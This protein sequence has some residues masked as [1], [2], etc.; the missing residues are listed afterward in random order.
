M[1]KNK[2]KNSCLTYQ[3]SDD[4]RL[5]R[6]RPGAASSAE[7][8][9][10]IH[11][12]FRHHTTL[13]EKTPKRSGSRK[14]SGIAS[15]FFV[16]DWRNTS[17]RRSRKVR[18]C[19]SGAASSAP[20]TSKRM[21]KARRRRPRRSLRGRFAPMF[22]A[23][24]IAANPSRKQQLPAPLL[25]VTRPNHRTRLPSRGGTMNWAS[26]LLPR[27]NFFASELHSTACRM[28][29]RLL[30][31]SSLGFSP[32]ARNCS[33]PSSLSPPPP[34][35]FSSTHDALGCRIHSHT[36]VT[37]STPDR[38][39]QENSLLQVVHKTD[40]GSACAA[41]VVARATGGTYRLRMPTVPSRPTLLCT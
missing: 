13:L 8:R 3:L 16:R 39:P 33:D 41:T 1:G 37:G 30:L 40:R 25:R 22:C 18:T 14:S 26:T 21:A 27:P 19:S 12:S 11:R 20:P 4:H 17:R 36:T 2:E 31:P 9:F 24:S 5:R 38:C 15:A 10:K 23:S 7:Q 6:R 32:D 35:G 34:G 28:R 29:S